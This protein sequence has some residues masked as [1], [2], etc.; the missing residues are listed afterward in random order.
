MDVM[1][2]DGYQLAIGGALLTC[3]ALPS[4]AAFAL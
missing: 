3:L 2:M 4:A 1:V